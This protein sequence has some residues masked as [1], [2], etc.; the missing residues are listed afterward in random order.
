MRAGLGGAVGT[1]A[2]R[3]EDHP[4]QDDEEDKQSQNQQKYFDPQG[5][6][7]AFE[8]FDDSQPTGKRQSGIRHQIHRA[9]ILSLIRN[10]NGAQDLPLFDGGT[11]GIG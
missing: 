6:E 7:K 2:G 11:K 8:K 10:G 3:A 9:I 1:A 4:P 5:P